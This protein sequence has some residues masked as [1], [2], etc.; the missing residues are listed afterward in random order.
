MKSI[1]VTMVVMFLSLG[2]ARVEAEDCVLKIT[3]LKEDG[4]GSDA[5][6]MGMSADQAQID[7]VLNSPANKKIT[8]ASLYLRENQKTKVDQRKPD[9][10]RTLILAEWLGKEGESNI[11]F[12]IKFRNEALKPNSTAGEANMAESTSFGATLSMA[13]GSS[14]LIRQNGSVL[15]VALQKK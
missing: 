11:K 3:L 7:A 5:D 4:A 15:V 9:S 10:G 8:E 1:F 13:P 12:E 2:L 14:S 6:R